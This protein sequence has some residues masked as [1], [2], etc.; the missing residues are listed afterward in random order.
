VRD[1]VIDKVISEARAIADVKFMG[2]SDPARQ[3]AMLDLARSI[4]K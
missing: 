4:Y 3:N 1:G 2:G